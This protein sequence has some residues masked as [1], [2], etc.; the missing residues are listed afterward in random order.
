MQKDTKTNISK[1]VR[2]IL[3]EVGAISLNPP[4]NWKDQV[5]QKLK[6]MN[7]DD[8]KV[9]VY[10]IRSKE[11][12][13]LNKDDVA[14]IDLQEYGSILIELRTLAKKVGGIDKLSDFVNI[15]KELKS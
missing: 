12:N 7:I 15:L 13:K 11:L 6:N 8:K 1:I 3:Q 5:I 9:N 2:D 4:A 14:P 10:A